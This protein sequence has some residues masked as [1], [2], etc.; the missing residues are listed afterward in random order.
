MT[1]KKKLFRKD[2]YKG[3]KYDLNIIYELKDYCNNKFDNSQLLKKS[4][5]LA[6]KDSDF[7]DK[8]TTTLFL[9][10]KSPDLVKKEYDKIII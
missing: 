9:K 2:T 8:F 10:H 3:K 6:E 1:Q 7:R 5:H 4:K